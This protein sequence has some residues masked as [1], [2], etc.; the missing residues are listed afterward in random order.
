MR[1]RVRR[2]T[3]ALA[4]TLLLGA[5][6]ACTGGEDQPEKTPT[7]PASTG[8]AATLQAR[9]VPLQVSVTRVAGK[10]S[11]HKRKLL[12]QRVGRTVGSYFDAAFLSGGYPR[13]GFSDAFSRFTAGAAQQAR[14][15]ADLLTNRRLG[16]TVDRIVPKK[17][18]VWLSVLA[19]YK[20]PAGVTGRF[21][22]RFVAERGDRPTKNVTVTGQLYLTHKKSGWRIFGYHVARSAKEVAG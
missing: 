2:A 20:V 11:E 15:D 19:P 3:A 8:T 21:E 18:A 7:R 4:C 16:P 5:A 14:R 6:G 17:R 13:S 22:L 9:P 10:L 1:T 12:E